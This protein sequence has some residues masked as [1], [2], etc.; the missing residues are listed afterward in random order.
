MNAELP[1]KE[2]LT[3]PVKLVGPTTTPLIFQAGQMP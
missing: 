1:T 3:Q 2:A